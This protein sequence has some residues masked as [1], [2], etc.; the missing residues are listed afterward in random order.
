MQIYMHIA[1]IMQ[2]ISRAEACIKLCAARAW[3][4]RVYISM[5]RLQAIKAPRCACVQPCVRTPPPN[6]EGHRGGWR[7][8]TRVVSY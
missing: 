8:N 4:A 7:K 5:P 6:Q 1:Y 2:C 3:A